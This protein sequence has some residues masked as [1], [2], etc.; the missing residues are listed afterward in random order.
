MVSLHIETA[1]FKSP[2]HKNEL[3]IFRDTLPT[4]VI[5]FTPVTLVTLF[6]SY[7]QFFRAE[8]IT[9]SRFFVSL[10]PKDTLPITEYIRSLFMSNT[11]V[12]INTKGQDRRSKV[13]TGGFKGS[14]SAPKGKACS[15]A[16][17]VRINF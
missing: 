6:R 14:S 9:V 15:D 17:K 8:C 2:G 10:A 4:M 13:K 7:N 1:R 5:L 12:F 3:S 16:R 11:N